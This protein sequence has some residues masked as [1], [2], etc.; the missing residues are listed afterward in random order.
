LYEVNGFNEELR[1]YWGEDGDLF[2]RL[3]NAGA[4]IVG[5]KGFA[6]Q[7]HLFHPR[8]QQTIAQERRYA[9]ILRDPAY[10][11]CARG[12]DPQA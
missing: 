4:R 2:V 8:L 7:Y 1:A 9:E 5:R 11:R 10:R 3:R 6:I 12:I